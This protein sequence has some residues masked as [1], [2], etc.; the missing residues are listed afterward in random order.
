MDSLRAYFRL[1]HEVPAF[2]SYLTK[3][4]LTLTLIQGPLVQEWARQ[5]GR[6]LDGMD[7][8]TEDT[9]D[10]WNQFITQFEA[11]FDDTQKVQK[12]QNQLDRLTMKWPEVDQY[13][14]DFEK[15]TREA[16]YRIGSPESI[17]MYLKGLPDNVAADILGP[18]L[19]H[20]YEAIKNRVAQSVSTR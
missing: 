2:Q 15:L 3:I 9:L 16:N 7:P 17:Q 4:A 10:T 13:T 11:S 5:T 19:V 18:P 20:T 1:N 8:V 6:W 12:A 14:M